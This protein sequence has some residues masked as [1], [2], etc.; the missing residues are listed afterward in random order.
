MNWIGGSFFCI[1]INKIPPIQPVRYMGLF[2]G[3]EGLVVSRTCLRKGMSHLDALCMG[4]M[5]RANL[6]E[7]SASVYEEGL[8]T[9]LIIRSSHTH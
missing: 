2:G 8:N 3:R 4:H 9:L 7:S 5:L 6:G 1:R